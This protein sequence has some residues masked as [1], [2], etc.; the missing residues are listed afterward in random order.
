MA[1]IA[2]TAFVGFLPFD[3]SRSSHDDLPV[4]QNART[5][6]FVSVLTH[7]SIGRT[8]RANAFVAG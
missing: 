4:S 8:A 2:F 7:S 1:F 3:R 5:S 6:V